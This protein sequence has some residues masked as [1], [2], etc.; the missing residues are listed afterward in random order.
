M[1]VGA[2]KQSLKKLH[3]NFSL[4]HFAFYSTTL[5]WK[6]EEKI[7]ME[8]SLF[9]KNITGQ[10][11]SSL[12]CTGFCVAIMTNSIECRRQFVQKKSHLMAYF[13][14]NIHELNILLPDPPSTKCFISDRYIICNWGFQVR[15]CMYKIVHLGK[16]FLNK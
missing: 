10:Q 5:F 4:T 2:I 15:A 6:K 1:E 7:F 11:G 16:F 14:Y 13:S 12:N 8:I 9:P 3:Y